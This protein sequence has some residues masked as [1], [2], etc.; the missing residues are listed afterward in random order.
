MGKVICGVHGGSQ[1][2]ETCSHIAK[3]IAEGKVPG[4]RRFLFLGELL[5]CDEC[6]ASLYF[7]KFNNIS[8]LPFDDQINHLDDPRWKAIE[9]A[10]EG[11]EGREV[12]CAR[13][14]AALEQ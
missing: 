14:I 3:R 5:I 6:T 8:D 4:G 9:A 12:F 11:M 13:C 7:E 1:L 10:Y 2:V